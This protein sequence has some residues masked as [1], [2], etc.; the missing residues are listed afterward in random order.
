MN[1]KPRKVTDPI[2]NKPMATNIFGIGGLFFVILLGILL[3]F[4][5]SSIKTLTDIS[6]S[7]GAFDGLLEE[8]LSLFFT[9]FVMLQFWN[10]FNA[11][12]FM[13]GKSTFSGILSCKWFLVIAIV[14]FFGQILIVEVGGQMFNVC[15]LGILDWLIIVGVTSIVL[16]IGELARAIK[17]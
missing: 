11:K 6:L 2:I 14:I 5:H 10:M 13:T 1:E 15:H 8:E 4:E 12:A 9:I 17:K 7:F 16:W 3:W